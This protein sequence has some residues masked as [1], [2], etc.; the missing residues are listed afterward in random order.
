MMPIW[1][2]AC[3][4]RRPIRAYWYGYT[5]HHITHS[6]AE[7]DCV[8]VQSSSTP[9]ALAARSRCH[10][11]A[12]TESGECRVH[13]SFHVKASEAPGLHGRRFGA[14]HHGV[15]AVPIVHEDGVV[16]APDHPSIV[17]S[18]CND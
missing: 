8:P 14:R 18:R 11:T 17:R 5:P 16:V 7:P 6:F 10:V 2:T 15:V 12:D 3:A 1:G 9:P 4:M 13:R